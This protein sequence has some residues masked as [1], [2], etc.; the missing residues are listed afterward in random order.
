MVAAQQPLPKQLPLPQPPPKLSGEQCVCADL[1]EE[2]DRRMHQA[3]DAA[4]RLV[5][6]LAKGRMPALMHPLKPSC[7]T[8]GLMH[9]AVN[10]FIQV[11]AHTLLS[12]QLRRRL[13]QR[14]LL[15]QRLLGCHRRCCC[16]LPVGGRSEGGG[17]AWS[18]P[19]GGAATE[20]LCRKWDPGL[21]ALKSASA[22]LYGVLQ[23]MHL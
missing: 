17:G 21:L 10:L 7:R 20:G 15:R 2:I 1:D 18:Q 11:S 23:R 4:R 6:G 14:Q 16:G 19:A 22:L 13:R 8:E 12:R 9:P 3:F 5:R